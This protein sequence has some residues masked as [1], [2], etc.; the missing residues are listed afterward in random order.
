MALNADVYVS[1]APTIMSTIPPTRAIPPK[2]GGN[3]I[4]LC[5]VLVA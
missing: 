2:I 4:V 1:F 3:G 5:S